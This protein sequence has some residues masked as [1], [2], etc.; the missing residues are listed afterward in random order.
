[1]NNKIKRKLRKEIRKKVIEFNLEDME[2][3]EIKMAFSKTFPRTVSGTNFP[4]WEEITLTPEEEA[5]VEEECRKENF[6]LMDECLGDA[7]AMVIKNSINTDENR[8]K[9][10]IALFEKRA[11][12]LVY[13]KESRAKE[14][15]DVK[16]K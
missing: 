12:H 8:I 7:K 4:V 15:F 10:A 14:K 11:S 5:K 16:F 13:W 9:L 3:E 1:K 6:K 2:E